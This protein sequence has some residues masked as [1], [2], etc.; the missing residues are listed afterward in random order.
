[1][2]K[3]RHFRNVI[4]TGI[5]NKTSKVWSQRVPFNIEQLSFDQAF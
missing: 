2:L 3:F 5:I 1:M 4:D